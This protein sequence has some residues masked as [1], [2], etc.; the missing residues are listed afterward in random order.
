[1]EQITAKFGLIPW[2]Y[3]HQIRLKVFSKI[4]PVLALTIFF[5]VPMVQGVC[6]HCTSLLH[7]VAARLSV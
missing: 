6:I 7:C 1:M 4:W 3:S 5:I 2:L